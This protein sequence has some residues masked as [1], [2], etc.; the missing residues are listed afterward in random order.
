MHSVNK[1]LQN[2]TL[3]TQLGISLVTPPLVCIWLASYLQK[4]FSLGIWV[5]LVAIAVGLLASASTAYSFYKRY[6]VRNR[7]KDD[8]KPPVSFNNHE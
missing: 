8:G 7:K 4:K 1:F 5:M 3:L 6:Q 2:L